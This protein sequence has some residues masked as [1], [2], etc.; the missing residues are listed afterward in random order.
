MHHA[1]LTS[2]RLT[3]IARWNHS[4]SIP[5]RTV[6]RLSADDSGRTPVKVGH[7]QAL[8]PKTPTRDRVGV[9]FPGNDTL[10]FFTLF[11]KVLNYKKDQASFESKFNDCNT[12][13]NFFSKN[14]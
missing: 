4:F 7:C 1:R 12:H 14:T 8:I 6:K 9:L 13:V 3:T 5:N 11:A 2:Y 10:Y